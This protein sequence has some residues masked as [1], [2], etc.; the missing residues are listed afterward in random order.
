MCGE[1]GCHAHAHL[2]LNEVEHGFNATC[3][4]GWFGTALTEV[5][6]KAWIAASGEQKL[7]T[8]KNLARTED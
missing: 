6:L 8:G 5:A 3:L 7:R 2:R 1:P 4:Q